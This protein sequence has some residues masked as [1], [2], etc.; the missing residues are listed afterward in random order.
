MNFEVFYW[1]FHGVSHE[2][3]DLV[4]LLIFITAALMLS[5][6]KSILY[7]THKL[8]QIEISDLYVA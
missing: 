7:L 6:L 4:N 1:K 2:R 8:V 5:F 3:L